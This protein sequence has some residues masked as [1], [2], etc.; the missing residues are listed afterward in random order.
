MNTAKRVLVVAGARPNFMKVAPLLNELHRYPEEFCPKLIHTGQHYDAEMSDVFFQDL[1][2]PRPDHCLGVGSGS[3]AEQTAKVMVA[4]ERVC[5]EERP[6]LVIVVGDVN[7]TMA[8]A[9]VAKKLCLRVAHIEAGLRSRDRTMPEEI[10]RVLT[11]SISDFLFTTSRDADDNLLCEGI[12]SNKI[13]FVGNIMI[14]CLLTQLPRTECRSTLSR[15]DVTAGGY[16]VL[17]LHR[18]SNVDAP[19]TLG[20]LVDVFVELSREMPIVWPIHPRTKTRLLDSG[21]MRRLQQS[22]D[23]KLTDPMNY[24]DMLTLNRSARM[25]LTDSGGLQEEATVLGVPC[26]TL[27]DNTERPVTVDVGTNQLVGN[28]PDR[29]RAAVRSALNEN[30]RQTRVPAFWDGKTSERIVDVLRR[31]WLNE[32]NGRAYF[33]FASATSE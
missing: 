2:L 24:L 14:D 1:D 19:E 32:G 10:N 7:S 25:I 15:F 22:K 13:H 17:T 20:N 33:D 3:H 6:D 29:I 11:D 27:R 28:H 4:F 18:P 8:C 9:I 16:A 21:L 26:I 12:P 23:L 31:Y 30:G 5:V